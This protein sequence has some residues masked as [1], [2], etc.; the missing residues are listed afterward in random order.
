MAEIV[1]L[2]GLKGIYTIIDAH[3]DMFSRLFCGEGVPIFYAKKKRIF[4]TIFIAFTQNFL[5]I[6]T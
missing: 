3:Q 5:C 6:I 4:C 1:R 2:L